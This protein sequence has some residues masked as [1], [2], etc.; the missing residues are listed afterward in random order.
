MVN[1]EYGS[2]VSILGTPT[3]DGYKFLYWQGSQY[4]PGGNYLVEGANTFTAVWEEVTEEKEESAPTPAPAPTVEPV[5]YNT[6]ATPRTGDDSSIGMWS[7]MFAA[8]GLILMISY[9]KRTN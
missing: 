8:A 4:N 1:A 6:D 7:V 9:K 5:K 3:R 2:T